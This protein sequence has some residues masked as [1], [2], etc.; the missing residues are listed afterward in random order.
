MG[1]SL[2]IILFVFFVVALGALNWFLSALA[3]MAA[4]ADEEQRARAR[5]ARERAAG[6]RPRPAQAEAPPPP[7]PTRRVDHSPEQELLRQLLGLEPPPPPPRPRPPRPRPPAAPTQPPPVLVARPVEGPARPSAAPLVE[8]TP[9]GAS[10]GTLADHHL[11]S[12]LAEHHLTSSITGGLGARVATADA[13]VAAPRRPLAALDSLP[14]MA[15]A[16]VLAD[17]FGKPPGLTGRRTRLV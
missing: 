3:R 10:P 17:V 5:E 4:R 16:L 12:G 14:T 9:F 1:G 13:A 7:A 6:A 11:E 8:L 2:P 15:R